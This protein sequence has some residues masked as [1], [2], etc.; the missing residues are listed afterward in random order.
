[1]A[2]TEAEYEEIQDFG[3]IADVLIDKYPEDFG[4]V[5]LSKLAAVM[6]TNKSRKNKTIYQIKTY[7]P[8]LSMYASKNYI[9]IFYSEDWESWNDN[10]KAAMVA[11]ILFSIHS[12]GEGKLNPMDYKD[13][14][15]MLRTLGVD[16]LEDS[17]LP[18]ILN[19]KIEWQKTEG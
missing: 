12:D 11:S 6:V 10:A 2:Q 13:H 15:V 7:T 1:M 3:D 5:D 14:S 9:A 16:Y 19:E 8:P 4:H 18:D 17:D